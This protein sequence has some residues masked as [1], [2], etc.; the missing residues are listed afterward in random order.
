MKIYLLVA[1]SNF[2]KKYFGHSNVAKV[3]SIKNQFTLCVEDNADLGNKQL[4]P[5]MCIWIT[6]Q[7]KPL[8]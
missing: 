6:F 1:S 5:D 4:L 8:F 7:M 3:R 2:N